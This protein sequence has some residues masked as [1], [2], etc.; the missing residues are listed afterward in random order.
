MDHSPRVS[1][2]KTTPDFPGEGQYAG[3]DV[4]TALGLHIAIMFGARL[5]LNPALGLLAEIGYLMHSFTHT[6][7][8]AAGDV[9]V[10]VDLSE[11]AF[12]FG[13]YF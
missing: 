2:S 11:A 3:E 9:E 5:E 10:D 12:N 13:I 7:D 6:L 1:E 4:N 8:T